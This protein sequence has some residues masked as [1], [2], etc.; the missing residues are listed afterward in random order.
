M[1]IIFLGTSSG[2]PTRTRNVSGIAIKMINSKS[3]NLVDCGECT[4]HQILKTNL[5]LNNLQAI[6]ITHV[7]GDH[8]YG[9]PG[10]LASTAMSGR[11]DP[12]TI[13]AP[14]KLKSFLEN[15]QKVT[16][17][18]F[19]YEINFI[20][21]EDISKFIE[22]EE[23]DIEVVNLSHRVSSYAFGF[24]EKNIKPKLN[25]KKLKKEGI[26][27]GPAWGTLQNR[28]DVLLPG[29]KK[30]KS[31]DYLLEERKPRKIIVSGDNDDPWLLSE[32]SKSAQVLVHEATYTYEVAEKMAK[33]QHSSAKLVSLFAKEL[34]IPNLVFT[35]FS[36][37]YQSVNT[38]GP[39]IKDIENE[40]REFYDGNLFLANDFDV[41]HLNLN[42]KLVNVEL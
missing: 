13:I 24:I 3:W 14:G 39:S 20:S 17:T 12:L 25:I 31:Q 21:I 22:V 28:E 5:T 15:A 19:S 35:H 30:L 1:E 23:F 32:C 36:P 37:R 33:A 4:Q 11:T 16:Q 10:L 38:T 2:T 27:P 26:D 8:C 18:R 42:G 40:A 6:F 7:H 34:S 9:L 41:F 29:G